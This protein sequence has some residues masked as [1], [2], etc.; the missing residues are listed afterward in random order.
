MFASGGW[1]LLALAF[2]YWLVDVKKKQRWCFF[3]VIVGMNPLFIYLFDNFGVSGLVRRALVPWLSLL[4]GW[5][6]RV[7]VE[8]V[9]GALLWF[10]HWALCYWLYRRKIFFRL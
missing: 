5:A 9:A 2:S 10:I 8:L 4:L 3:L 1:T 7:P 6:G